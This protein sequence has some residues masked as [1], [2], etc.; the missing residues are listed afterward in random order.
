MTPASSFFE[1]VQLA[2]HS[3]FLNVFKCQLANRVGSLV[4]GRDYA[5]SMSTKAD[6]PI[7]SF[8][9][10][11]AWETWLAAQHATS[12]GLWLKIAKKESGIDSVTYAEAVE[13]AVC[14]GWIDGQAG[15]FDDE[16]WLQRFGP[17]KPRSRWSK[18]NRDRALR[19]IDQD[20]MRPAG[21]R[22]VERAKQDG[23]WDA[24]YEPQ[25]SA[26]VPDDLQRE[27]DQDDRARA[28]F[29]TL[30]SRN[31]Y[32]ILYRIQ[33]AKK[34]ETRK[35]RIERYVAMLHEQKKIYDT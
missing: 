20:R 15:S 32:A 10:R 24:A 16:H 26:A 29:A 17:R 21:L 2:Q 31:R 30:D 4:G 18:V 5:P 9:S 3:L 23:R 22:E 34:P 1:R 28:F 8:P 19:L 11:D 33:D 27:L 6:L 12:G 13:A 14:Y 25:S 35:R 7:M